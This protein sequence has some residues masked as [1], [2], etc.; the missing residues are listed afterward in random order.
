M[1]NN[2]E[3]NPTKYYWFDS[4]LELNMNNYMP[5]KLMDLEKKYGVSLSYTPSYDVFMTQVY[6]KK[7][8]R[9]K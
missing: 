9:R 1:A 6:I 7:K 3:V 4:Y 2:Q 5:S 8:R